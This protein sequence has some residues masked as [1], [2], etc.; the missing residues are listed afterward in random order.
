VV[1]DQT[2]VTLTPCGPSP[3]PFCQTTLFGDPVHLSAVVKNNNHLQ[4]VPTGSVVFT[5]Y[6]DTNE[7]A[8]N[9]LAKSDPIPV[10]NGLAKWPNP[11]MTTLPVGTRIVTATFIPDAN[12]AGTKTYKSI[13]NPNDISDSNRA[14]FI[15]AVIA[16]AEVCRATPDL[17]EPPNHKLIPIQVFLDPA[18]VGATGFELI[19]KSSNEADEGLG[20]GDEPN[21]IQ[22]WD[23]N[24]PDTQ[25]FLRAERSGNADGRTY[26]LTYRL[27]NDSGTLCKVQ[28]N[29]PH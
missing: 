4:L 6:N 18:R 1:P 26:T 24:T 5:I 7:N 3:T 11:A 8:A 16:P 21:D 28:V 27:F 9:I 20:D 2:T 12:F 15:H 19:S 17:L 25:G 23:L 13:S 10:V 29:V 14:A 22:G